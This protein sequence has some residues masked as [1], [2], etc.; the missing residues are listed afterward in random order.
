[1]VFGNNVRIVYYEK[2]KKENKPIDLTYCID[3]VSS[4]PTEKDSIIY[5]SIVEMLI[6]DCIERIKKFIDS[7]KKPEIQERDFTKELTELLNRFSKENGSNTP[8]M[9]RLFSAMEIK[10]RVAL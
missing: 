8:E 2:N 5:V 7:T 10:T 6:N 4:I 3:G 1:V 9:G